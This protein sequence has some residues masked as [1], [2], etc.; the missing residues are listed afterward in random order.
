MRQG[1]PRLKPSV[2]PRH[3]RTSEAEKRISDFAK[4]ATEIQIQ[5][6]IE[7]QNKK[8]EIQKKAL[9]E[10]LKSI[11]DNNAL[12]NSEIEREQSAE[13][14]ALTEKYNKGLIKEDAYQKELSKIER[15]YNNERKNE[16][17]AEIDKEI[18][19][20]Q[21]RLN[22]GGDKTQ[23]SKEIN[24]LLSERDKILTE[25]DKKTK[26]S[27]EDTLI[28]KIF[29]ID[30]TDASFAED[31]AKI[32][33][34][35]KD[36]VSS[37][38]AILK[39]Q[40]RAE[41]E[42]YDLAIKLQQDRVSQASK[43]AENGNA[44]YLQLEEERL[45][46]LEAKREA[47][48]RRQLEIDSAIQASQMLVAI[49][50]AVAQISQGGIANVIAGIGTITA[51]IATGYALMNQLNASRPQFYSGTETTVAEELGKPQRS[52]RDGYDI[53]V[54]G[55]EM[56]VNGKITKELRKRGVK[57]SDLPTLVSL[58]Q[59]RINE[60][61]LQVAKVEAMENMKGL[62][63]RLDKSEKIQKQMLGALKQIKVSANID[64][65]GV[66]SIVSNYEMDKLKSKFA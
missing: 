64:S 36:I 58:G 50:G 38:I 47:S 32:L 54:D 35:L 18:T 10:A 20:A 13:I 25:A 23:I 48:A 49:A 2:L 34:G 7:Y 42:A 27:A 60:V 6:E 19:N 41:L 53:S 17:L 57:A 43:I 39:E 4:N 11:K 45:T 28:G 63:S 26:V 5:N 46:E 62:E 37:S 59:R 12:A 29:G 15:K 56:I 9:E 21:D 8:A 1:F 66:A 61:G 65:R 31:K 30:P 33:G 40:T 3:K 24:D 51:T 52:G 22:A 55:S 16:R 44:E 14:L